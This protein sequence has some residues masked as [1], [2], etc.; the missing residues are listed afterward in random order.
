MDIPIDIQLPHISGTSFK[1]SSWGYLNVFVGPNGSGKTTV[2]RELKKRCAEVG[3]KP[4]YLNADRLTDFA[5]RI[6]DPAGRH[7]YESGFDLKDLSAL[8]NIA[9]ERDSSFDA[10]AILKRKIDLRIKIEATLSN[11]FGKQLVL[12][13]ESGFLKPKI[14][15]KTTGTEYDIKEQESHGLKEIISLLTLLYDDENNCI[16][17]D[18]PEL[19]LHPQFQTFFLSEV[20]KLAGDPEKGKKYFFIITHSPFFIELNSLDDLKNYLVFHID[21]NPT[22]IH[23]LDSQIERKL[24]R[25]FP[26]WNAHHKQMFFSSLPVFVEGYTDQQMMVLLQERR[27]KMIGANGI[28]IINVDGKENL[29]VFFRLCEQLQ[30][31]SSIICDLDILFKSEL[32]KTIANH[33]K[34][35]ESLTLKGL[36]PDF[37]KIINELGILLDTYVQKL[38]STATKSSNNED[39]KILVEELYKIKNKPHEK[40]FVLLSAIQRIPEKLVNII[41]NDEIKEINQKLKTIIEI[42]SL[43][44]IYILEKGQLENYLPTYTGNPYRIPKE[45]KYKVL[46][47]ELEEVIANDLK[48]EAVEQRYA[49]LITIADKAIP[50]TSLHFD[51]SLNHILRD[52]IHIIQSAVLDYNIKNKEDFE[53]NE[54]VNYE[55]F[56]RILQI[57]EFNKTETGFTCKIKLN[58]VIDSDER[59]FEIN[60]QLLPSKF[61]L[62]EIKSENL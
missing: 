39:H 15:Q 41:T 42:F 44:N 32:K 57:L 2:A 46:S 6:E 26:R 1:K 22:S 50:L 33:E 40:R 58:S 59:E 45:Q 5:Q 18:E 56:K 3:L 52:W 13:E 47:N 49:D 36:N 48:T 37:N 17:I 30:I 62:P 21:K 24:I 14:Q 61:Q 19:H 38:I 20:K 8:S 55:N 34:C 60:D 12:K 23:S 25:L 53:S 10:F 43:F 29:D 7:E 54:S 28:S 27:G 4:R 9:T 35:K 31:K 11:F 16:I 51:P